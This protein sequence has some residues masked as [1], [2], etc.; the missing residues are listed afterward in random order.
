VALVSVGLFAYIQKS[1]PFDAASLEH[2]TYLYDQR[3]SIPAFKLIDQNQREFTSEQIRNQWT[4]WFFGFTHC[5]DICPQTLGLLSAV[6]NKVS[7]EHNIDDLS[8]VFVSVDP[9]R[10]TPEDLKS[11]VSAFGENIIGATT[12]QAS[13]DKFLQNL[14]II[15]VKIKSENAPDQYT[16]DHS[17][18]VY[19]IAPDT[20]ISAL[21]NTPH[22]VSSISND[23]AK[24]IKS[25]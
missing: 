22:T 24:I 21:F 13:L 10:D 17:S 7:A 1:Q 5:P 8:I 18:S 12:D 19:L 14:G 25:Y 20:A 23:L 15:A 6:L 11:Y 4:L 9:D 16:F 3:V 2:A